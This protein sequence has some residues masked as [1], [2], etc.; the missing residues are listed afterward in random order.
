MSPVI[1]H[2]PPLVPLFPIK[3]ADLSGGNEFFQNFKTQGYVGSNRSTTGPLARP[4]TEREDTLRRR[5]FDD[6]CC[7]YLET[8]KLHVYGMIEHP[9]AVHLDMD[10]L[11]L[12]PMDDLFDAMLGV[13]DGSKLPLAR[14]PKTKTPDYTKPIDAAFTRDYNSVKQPGLDA[15]VGYQG[16]FLVVKPSLDVL[17]RY[18]E[19]LRRGE[20]ILDDLPNRGWGGKFGAFYGGYTFQGML[21]YYYEMIAPVG[22]HNEIELDRCIYNQMGDNPRKTQT[23][24]PQATP[25]DRKAMGYRETKICRDGR[26]DCSDT[27][28]Q[29]VHPKESITTHFTFC[30]KPW[31]CS[32]GLPGTVALSTCRG[33]LYEWHA[34]R[35]ELEDWWISLGK[36]PT[37]TSYWKNKTLHAVK[38][39]REEGGLGGHYNGYCTKGGGPQYYLSMVEP[40]KVQFST[41]SLQTNDDVSQS[42]N[43]VFDEVRKH[44]KTST[45]QHVYI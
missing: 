31:D 5:M 29:R 4:P 40:D 1:L 2:K 41:E 25:L 21:P 7:G 18:R 36:S 42:I 10:S 20:F 28:C 38:A 34:V 33:L 11:L 12:R 26:K 43:D 3:P 17:E 45:N 8:L 44:K 30:K 27:D 22:E 16:G 6:G 24:Y 15:Q 35:R 32:T 14:G 39:Q 37:E 9:L 19:I 23:K 13:T